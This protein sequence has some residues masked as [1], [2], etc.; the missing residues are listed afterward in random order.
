MSTGS[1]EGTQGRLY[2]PHTCSDLKGCLPTTS[3][4]V[5]LSDAPSLLRRKLPVVFRTN[6]SP[7]AAITGLTHTMDFPNLCSVQTKGPLSLLHFPPKLASVSPLSHSLIASPW[8]YECMSLPFLS[9]AKTWPFY[10]SHHQP[11]PGLAGMSTFRGPGCCVLRQTL[12]TN[13]DSPPCLRQLPSLRAE[14]W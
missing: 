13:T 3:F 4:L 7:D 1:E 8:R 5:L 10:T 2:S 12:I 9:P 14:L 6:E 11:L